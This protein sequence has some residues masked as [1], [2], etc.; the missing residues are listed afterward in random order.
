MGTVHKFDFM[1]ERC[2]FCGKPATKLCDIIISVQRYVGHPPRVNGIIDPE[3]P[4]E[5]KHTCDKP[6]CEKC[7]VHL[8]DNFDICPDHYKEIK[9]VGGN[10]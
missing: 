2:V 4:M 7:A 10:R 1:S 9:R 8:N 3:T 6:M 5:Y